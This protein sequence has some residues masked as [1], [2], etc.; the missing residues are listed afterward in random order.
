[1]AGTLCGGP[2]Q[3]VGASSP[4]THRALSVMPPSDM[5]T[6][7]PRSCSILGSR[8]P[9]ITVSSDSDEEAIIPV[10]PINAQASPD[11][12]SP[13]EFTGT[14]EI[15]DPRAYVDINGLLDRLLAPEAQEEDVDGLS[16][17]QTRTAIA[18]DVSIPAMVFPVGEPGYRFQL[19]NHDS[20]RQIKERLASVLPEAGEQVLVPV[21][22]PTPGILEFLAAS[23][24]QLDNGLVV[25]VRVSAA[26]AKAL[27]IHLTSHA[28]DVLSAL[29]LSNG[30]LLHE[31]R[32]WTGSNDGAF[33]GM[34]LHYA[35]SATTFEAAPLRVAAAK[36]PSVSVNLS[37]L[38]PAAAAGSED[39]LRALV[40]NIQIP[41]LGFWSRNLSLP[42][43][44]SAVKD[45][46]SSS[47][48]PAGTPLGFC[49]FTD[50]AAGHPGTGWGAILFGLFGTFDAPFWA[51]LGLAGGH[52][53][54][55][56]STGTNNQAEGCA[57]LHALTWAFSIAP[58]VP[59][60]IISDSQLVVRGVNGDGKPPSGKHRSQ[61]HQVCKYLKQMHEARH[62]ALE[63]Q[64]T[65]SHTGLAGNECADDIAGCFAAMGGRCD[66]PVPHAATSLWEH[67]LLPWAWMLWDCAGLPPLGVLC[68]PTYEP[69]EK[70][71]Q[72]CVE[73]IVSDM[74]LHTGPRE[75]FSLRIGTANVCSLLHKQPMLRHQLLE[76]Q[77]AIVVFKKLGLLQ[78]PPL[79]QRDGS[80]TIPPA[81]AVI[82]AVLCGCMVVYSRRLPMLERPRTGTTSLY[83][84]HDLIGW[85][86][87]CS[88]EY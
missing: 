17:I 13:P 54:I 60:T 40:R 43:M 12:G 65:R 85:P 73:S 29:G 33:P 62:S 77:I 71:P 11:V 39:T 42:G 82:R 15:P 74:A 70:P 38:C 8:G 47:P 80:A 61:L 87:A 81:N 24:A 16:L 22:P 26:T 57:L 2:A 56:G 44:A 72:A 50:G 32:I 45:F 67:P 83:L 58:C 59:V 28:G 27:V 68:A 78:P 20:F 14:W 52:V 49:V 6:L 7:N 53:R 88:G 55:N 64:W 46:L 3:K 79:N 4:S 34:V 75:A 5:Q 86:S 19:S 51:F 23:V 1:M 21:F 18:H 76:H 69:A 84:L 37:Q 35:C 63:V 10:L 66:T 9:L 48:P 31:G 36:L 30:H 25:L 41:W